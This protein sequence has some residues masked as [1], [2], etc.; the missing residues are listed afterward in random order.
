MPKSA[1]YDIASVL[2]EEYARVFTEEG[3]KMLASKDM[4]AGAA[5]VKAPLHQLP[6]SPQKWGSR[7]F[8]FGGIKYKDGN[9]MRSPATGSD[10]ERLLDYIS[11]AQRHLTAWANDI[12]R[13]RGGGIKAKS[14]QDSWYA[15][16]PESG[17][18]HG[19]H[20]VASLYM[21]IQQGADAGLFPEDPGITWEIGKDG[22]PVAR[23]TK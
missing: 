10:E 11:A 4:K 6:P 8:Q 22:K 13:Q 12:M 20:A 5:G 18:P 19:A 15:A 23:G 21:A 3:R 7:A 16:D 2:E 1:R 17:L 14:P 9:Y